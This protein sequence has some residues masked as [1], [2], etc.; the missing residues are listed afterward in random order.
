MSGGLDSATLTAEAL[1]QDFDVY[2][3]NFNYNQKN[4][5]ELQAFW[6]LIDFFKKNFNNKIIGVK[7]LNLKPLFDEFLDV[8]AQM[9]DKGKI[10]EK[11][12]HQFYAPS[13]NLLFVVISVVIGEIIA[14]AKDYD[15]VYVGLGI[16][17]HTKD[18]YGEHRNYWD[19]TSEFAQKL[20]EIF[21]LN[22]VKKIK[23]FAPFTN[24]F[25]KDIIKRAMELQ[26]PY[27]LTWTCYNP[28]IKDDVALPCLKCEACIERELAGKV[29]G[30]K[31][32]NN[33]AVHLNP[34]IE[35]NFEKK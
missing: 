8:W 31:D 5:P 7:Q 28:V 22:D 17:Q 6:N 34:L 14:L 3:L 15:E 10:K 18:A 33:Y 19:I 4:S 21:D 29:A 30:V 27:H 2:I 26:V 9:R 11:A 13:R 24:K 12:Q 32:I 20:Q 35:I 1:H 16:H 23:V 25:K